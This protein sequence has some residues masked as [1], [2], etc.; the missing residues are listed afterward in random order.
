M[1]ID[2]AE[3]IGATSREVSRQHT[4]S[5]E[6]VAVTLQRRY[7]ADPADVW[8][9]ITDPERVRR[10]FMPLTGDLR[11][12]G[13]FQLEGNA[14]GD[15]LKCEPPRH[16]MVTFGGASS[17]VDVQLSGESQ[18]T[19]LKLTHS[20]PIELAGS[21]A[22]ALYVGPG[23]DGALMGIAVYLAGEVTE[24]LVA[25]A[26]SPQI[27]DFNVSSIKEWVASIEASGTADADAISAAQQVSLA[28][29][30]PDLVRPD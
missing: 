14:S 22:G 18:Q 25:A 15:I 30:A 26:N 27:Q 4:E 16:L 9:A 13:N 24:D 11:E 2:I 1:I 19:L 21:G 12:G 20:V 29:F 23:W 8:E 7:L 6:T 17:I 28:Q 3:Q 10:W 5:G